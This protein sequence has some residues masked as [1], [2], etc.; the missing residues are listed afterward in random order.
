MSFKALAIV[1][2]FD[3][4]ADVLADVFPV[5]ILTDCF[6]S[7]ISTW[8][9]QVRVM[10]SYDWYTKW[11]RYGHFLVLRE[12]DFCLSGV[13]CSVGAFE[14]LNKFWVAKFEL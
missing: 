4:R 8:V 12:D 1:A 9:T 10:P 13:G 11:F 3:N 5:E 14:H 6:F 2:F 7:A